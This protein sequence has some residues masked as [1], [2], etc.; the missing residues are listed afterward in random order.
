MSRPQKLTS[1]VGPVIDRYLALKKALG[2]KYASERRVLECLDVFLAAGPDDLT[3]ETFAS[4]CATLKCLSPGVRRF[5]MRVVRNLCLYRRR[6]EPECLVPD[7]ALFP[8]PHQPVQPHI[9]SEEE[10]CRLARVVD[11]LEPTHHSPIRRDVFRLAV[12]LLYTTGLRRGELLRMKIGD[13]DSSEGTLLVRSTKFHKSR[14]LPLS[15]DGCAEMERHLQIRR[16]RGLPVS[17]DTPLIWNARSGGRSYTEGGFGQGM[18]RLFL[19]AAIRT[20][21]GRLPRVHDFR[22]AFA[23]HALVRWYRSG[24]DVHA[25]LPFLAIYMGHV[26]I[27]STAY[28]LRFI[29]LVTGEAAKRFSRHCQ[30][31][32][33]NSPETTGGGR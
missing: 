22:H 28:Y 5:R 11:T 18:R 19:A 9:F 24:V 32:I 33:G 23:V 14:L 6:T 17:E 16:V 31:I 20:A 13:F 26:S 2:R 30:R 3:P 10:I 7:L 25:K 27:V 8:L 4:W 1:I 29:D 21:D 12:I 15:A